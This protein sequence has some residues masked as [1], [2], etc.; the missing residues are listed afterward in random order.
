VRARQEN[1]MVQT[2]D[3]GRTWMPLKLDPSFVGPAVVSKDGT[4]MHDLGAITRAGGPNKLANHT[5]FATDNCAFLHRVVLHFSL[6]S[7]FRND[8]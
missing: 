3:G 6:L 1:G 4:T 8:C 7:E 2:T 5:R